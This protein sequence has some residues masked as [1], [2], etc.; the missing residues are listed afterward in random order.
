[1]PEPI[2]PERLAQLQQRWERDPNSRLF[3]QLAE[4]YRRAG[5]LAEA[6]TTLDEGLSRH[7]SYLSAQVAMGRCLLE[8]GEPARAKDWLERAIRQDP[9]QLVANKLLVESHLALGDLAHARERLDLYRLLNDGDAEIDR[10][11]SRLRQLGNEPA[12]LTPRRRAIL[13]E[14]DEVEVFALPKPAELPEIELPPARDASPARVEVPREQPFGT[15]YPELAGRTILRAFERAG[16]FAVA[17]PPPSG[18]PRHAAAVALAT[19][20]PVELLEPE[21]APPVAAWSA[22]EP[23][24]AWNEPEP[25]AAMAEATPSDLVFSPRQAIGAE[26][27][28]VASEESPAE[29]PAPVEPV[30]TSTTLGELY[31]AQGHFDEAERSFLAVLAERPGDAAAAA[32]L[33]TTRRLRRSA[34]E[35]FAE[36]VDAPSASPAVPGRL[37]ARKI[38]LLKDYM[39]RLRRRA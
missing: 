7:P 35:E 3:L 4:E 37:A 10:L 6:V 39:A 34:D 21:P 36:P 20:A 11:E 38:A 19:P 17:G 27:E 33:E 31:L 29:A 9:T 18:A 30:P 12:A 23:T 13:D 24:I 16:I 26:L 8:V 5:R 14:R 15:I 28:A 22:P 25:A 1:M 32:G 2:S